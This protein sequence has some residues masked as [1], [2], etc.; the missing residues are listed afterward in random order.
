[1]VS[2][3]TGD[4]IMTKEKTIEFWEKEIDK[5]RENMIIS[6]G[7]DPEPLE[8]SINDRILH[9]ISIINQFIIQIKTLD[10]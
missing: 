8:K 6:P 9:E 7:A 1:M 10:Y 4:R 5:L 3:R 2:R